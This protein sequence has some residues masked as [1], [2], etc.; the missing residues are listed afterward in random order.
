VECKLTFCLASCAVRSTVLVL[1]IVKKDPESGKNS[2]KRI[3]GVITK[4]RIR[5]I[6]FIQY[7]Y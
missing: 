1:V 5:N 2:S 4:H 6:E 3:Q 7:R